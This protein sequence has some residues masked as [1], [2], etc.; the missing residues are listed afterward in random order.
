MLSSSLRGVRG[1]W[2]KRGVVPAISSSNVGRTRDFSAPAP[3]PDGKIYEL[4]RYKIKPDKFTELVRHTT[5]KY[6]DIM[7]PYGKLL[8]YWTS[9]LGSQCEFRHLW[10][11]GENSQ[12][13]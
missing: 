1:P 12:K 5:E 2:L 6:K 9:H 8:G 4:R 13:M 10:E 3:P 7:M 11:Y